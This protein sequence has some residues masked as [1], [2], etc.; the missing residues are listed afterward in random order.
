MCVCCVCVCVFVCVCVADKEDKEPLNNP[1][2]AGMLKC[3]RMRLSHLNAVSTRTEHERE[4]LVNDIL[5]ANLSVFYFAYIY[6]K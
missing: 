1:Q 5:S 4:L 3:H 6:N 2:E